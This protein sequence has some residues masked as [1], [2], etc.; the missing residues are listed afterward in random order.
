[1]ERIQRDSAEQT[2]SRVAEPICRECVRHF[3]DGQREQQ[4]DERDENL[5]EVDGHQE[6]SAVDVTG[7]GRLA[8]NART[9]SATF[10]PT[11]HANSSRVARRTPGRLPNVV[12]RRLR[13][14]APTP[15]TA[16]SSERRSRIVRAR[17]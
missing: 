14:R 5:C 3:V 10:G 6:G 12:N 17:R 2:G 9:A 1:N 11:T 15:G 16:S 13:R 7:Y 4:N 8:K